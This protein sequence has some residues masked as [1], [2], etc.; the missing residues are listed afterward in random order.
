M[1][2]LILKTESGQS[3]IQLPSNWADI[4]FDQFLDLHE[5]GFN[6]TSEIIE[7]FTGKEIEFSPE[8][9]DMLTFVFHPEEILAELPEC[10]IV[11]AHQSWEK[12]EMAR[13]CIDEAEGDPVRFGKL[14]VKIYKGK[15][16]GPLPVPVAIGWVDFFFHSSLRLLKPIRNYRMSIKP[17]RKRW[18][19]YCQMA[20][21][22]LTC[23]P[24]RPH[25]IRWHQET[26]ECWYGIDY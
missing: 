9:F 7:Y 2:D 11:I 26:G 10:N 4:T 12:F 25:C 3:E 5:I 6:N 13:A 21:T 14:L 20:Q 8:I 18:R 15:K 19:I 16:I 1:I 23:F 24:G 22:T 17:D